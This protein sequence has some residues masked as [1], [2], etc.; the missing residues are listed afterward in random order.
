M[1][2]EAAD[3]LSGCSSV[4]VCVCVFFFR[5]TSWQLFGITERDGEC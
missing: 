2:I 4:C 3:R 1:I 5:A